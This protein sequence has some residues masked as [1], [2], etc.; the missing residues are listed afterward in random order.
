MANLSAP[1]RPR[2]QSAR[3]RVRLM[4]SSGGSSAAGGTRATRAGEALTALSSAARRRHLSTGCTLAG[5]DPLTQQQDLRQLGETGRR[6]VAG[7]EG[8]GAAPCAHQACEE[9]SKT[10]ARRGVAGRSEQLELEIVGGW[11]LGSP[12]SPV[13]RSHTMHYRYF[14]RSGSPDIIESG[15][16][17]GGQV[18]AVQVKRYE[19]S[20]PRATP[21]SMSSRWPPQYDPPGITATVACCVIL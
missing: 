11:A 3:A 1:L 10:C 19:W 15:P 9:V 21:L 6:L 20:A 7:G 17:N 12:A 5:S 2:T 13:S 4:A 14:A 8:N 18:R 16:S